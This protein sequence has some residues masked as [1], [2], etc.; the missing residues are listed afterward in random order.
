LRTLHIW[1]AF[2]RFGA[3]CVRE[4]W[5]WIALTYGLNWSR[6]RELDKMW[7]PWY[8]HNRRAK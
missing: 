7:C 1:I 2:A 3:A 4:Y 6:A 5:A 8:H